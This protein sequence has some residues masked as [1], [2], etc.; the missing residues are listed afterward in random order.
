MIQWKQWK[1]GCRSRKLKHQ[2]IARPEVEHCHWFLSLLPATPTMQFS[3][4]FSLHRKQHPDTSRI[5]V[6]LPI[7]PVWFSLDRIALRASDYDSDSVT[8]ENQPLWI[9]TV[10]SCNL[11]SIAKTFNSIG[12]G[13]YLPSLHVHYSLLPSTPAPTH[14]TPVKYLGHAKTD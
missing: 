12:C 8:G 1:P 2:P 14:I 6:L 13:L 3:R 7:P 9:D 11:S 10:S 5:S 4:Q